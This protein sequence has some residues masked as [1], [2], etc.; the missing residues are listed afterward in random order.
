MND[1]TNGSSG[2]FEIAKPGLG[3]RQVD[4]VRAFYVMIAVAALVVWFVTSRIRD[5]GVGR[6]WEAIRE[7]EDVAAGM[8][9]NTT[10]YKLMA[11]STGA[12]CGALG[13]AV[14]APF[15]DFVAP[16]SFG[17][18]VSI[19]VLALVIIGGMGSTQGVVAGALILIG[20]PE[21]LQFQETRDFLGYFGW[22]RDLL[23]LV[24]DGF[25][26]ITRL[27]ID[28]LPPAEEWGKK[29]ALYRFIVY[30]LLLVLVMVLR[31]SGIFPSRRR[32]MEFANEP[33]A[34]VAQPGGSA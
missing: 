25:N 17:L 21:L 31:P 13:G 28:G 23:N 7:D 11:F 16:Q 34:E 24:I 14:Y 8:G 5:S 10:R 12:A 20:V 33:E 27:D 2:L 15:I 3:F 4:D 22:L 9:I 6:A 18:I 30:G 29:L 1:W 26:F 32:R 19:N